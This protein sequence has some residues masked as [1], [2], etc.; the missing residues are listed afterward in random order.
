MEKYNWVNAM[1]IKSATNAM[2]E[3]AIKAVL[4]SSRRALVS[5]GVGRLDS[6]ELTTNNKRVKVGQAHVKKG[7]RP[8]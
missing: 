6:C 4:R 3:V 2:F 7:R 5:I 8:F 1:K